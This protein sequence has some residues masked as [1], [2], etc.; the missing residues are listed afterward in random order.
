MTAP[1]RGRRVPGAT[2]SR[3]IAASPC[4][5]TTRSSR[6]AGS[7]PFHV[8]VPGGARLPVAAVSDRDRAPDAPPSRRPAADDG[9][10]ARRRRAAWRTARRAHRVGGIDLRA[11]RLRHR[12]VHDALGARLGRTPGCRTARRRRDRVRL[13]D[14]DARPRPPRT[15]CTRASRRARSASSTRPPSGGR[16]IFARRSARGARFFTAVHEDADGTP[17]AFARYALDADWPDAVPADTLRVHRDPGR[18]RRR[19]GRDVVVTSSAS[20]WSAPSSAASARSTTRCA[21]VSPIL[22][23]CASGSCVT[24]SGCASR[25]RRRA[26]GAHLR[27]RRRA[28]A[29]AGSTTSGPTNSRPLAR[30]RRSRRRHVHAHRPRRRP[31]AV[32]APTS[33]RSPRWRAGVDARRRRT[34]ARAHHRRRRPRRPRVP[35]AP[36]AVV[37]HAL[38]IAAAIAG[39]RSGTSA[40]RTRP[41]RGVSRARP[42][43]G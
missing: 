16:T 17:D 1:P 14:G 26:G 40:F 43:A 6:T 31:R 22:A 29:R 30:R 39:A 37:H 13:V 15:R 25:R 38:L 24:T 2:S 19:R 9:R 41:R 12:D 20:T 23:A 35:R 4:A 34:C 33:A 27:R 8:T 7:L 11:L 42:S 21:G 36:V 10:A 3:P 28:R 32:G 5:T 18:R